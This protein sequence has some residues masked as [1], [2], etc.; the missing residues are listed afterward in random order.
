MEVTKEKL[1]SPDGTKPMMISMREMEI[2]GLKTGSGLRETVPFKVFDKATIMEQIT[3]MGFMCPFHEYRNEL[4]VRSSL[5]YA[6]NFLLLP[7]FFVSR[8]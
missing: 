4:S 7:D 2:L 3:Q 8:N 1:P 6:I 5:S